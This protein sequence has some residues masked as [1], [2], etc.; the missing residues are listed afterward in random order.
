M[1]QII[2]LFREYGFKK[3]FI[4]WIDQWL[5]VLF[6]LIGGYIGFLL[7]TLVYKLLFK[8]L[9]GLF[10]IRPH[11]YIEHSYG[12]SIGK[13]CHINYG[14]YI[15]ARGGISIGNHVLIGPNCSI[16][17]SNHNV[18]TQNNR[19]NEGHQLSEVQIGNNVWIGS[20]CS[21]MPGITIGNNSIIAA[22]SVVIES[23]PSNT[24]VAG[25][26]AKIKKVYE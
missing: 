19:L 20:N 16:V 14:T 13:D 25:V 15:D 18:N 12:M 17:S 8:K 23:I 21:I 22:G 1:S 11:V 10:F 4:F 6:C 3:I 9:D 26:P 24:M 5:N 2:R 7:K